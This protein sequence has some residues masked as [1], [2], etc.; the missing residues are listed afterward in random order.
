MDNYY[1]FFDDPDNYNFK[2]QF[3]IQGSSPT[4]LKNFINYVKDNLQRIDTI[5]LCLYLYNN[6]I[7]HKFLR[8]ISNQ[9]VKVKVVSIPIE[10]Y[11]RKNASVLYDLTSENIVARNCSKYSLAKQIY[12]DAAKNHEE[13][14][15]LFIFPHMY[16]RS[17]RVQPFSRGNMPYSLHT[18]SIYIKFKDGRGTVG[19]TS[20]NLAV[21]DMIKDELMFLIENDEQLNFSAES[22]FNDIIQYSYEINKFDENLDWL[23]Y[24]FKIQDRNFKLVGNNCNIYI[25][26]FYFNEQ[27]NIEKILLELIQ[28][29]QNQIYV[30]AQHIASYGN[31]PQFLKKILE[32]SKEGIIV[33]FLSQTFVDADGNS[34]GCRKPQNINAFKN[35]ISECDK[36]ENLRYFANAS[37]HSKFIVIDDI[38]IISTCN[39]TPTEFVYLENVKID[40]FENIKDLSYSGTFSEVGQFIIVKNINLCN[41]LIVQFNH[42][43]NRTST[44][45]H[46]KRK[47]VKF[48]INA[49]NRKCPKC[50]SNL[51]KRNGRYGDFFGCSNFP[52]CRYTENI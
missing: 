1:L 24:T 26:P 4:I 16:I 8:Y 36:Y 47:S 33:K 52:N 5:N 11:D 28:K 3:Y 49:Q 19:I 45:E 17:A 9:G 51:V 20:S 31:K 13:N 23:H 41:D 6:I 44:Y 43:C 21:R 18:K 50:G 15:K 25:S 32:K 7:L 42:I 35:F 48:N 2:N 29:S 34:N 12:D 27:T 37:V 30:C 10:G 40:H 22:F 46:Q 14:F 38:A 39:F